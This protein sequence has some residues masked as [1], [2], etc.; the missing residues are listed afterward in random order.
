MDEETVYCVL[1]DW[2]IQPYL[3]E[4][5]YT[6]EEMQRGVRSSQAMH[7]G[8]CRHGELRLHLPS[9]LLGHPHKTWRNFPLSIYT[10]K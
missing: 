5:D 6:A 8:T 1:S 10:M 2:D 4:P 7:P 3:F 9:T